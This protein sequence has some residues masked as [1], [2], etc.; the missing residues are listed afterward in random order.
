LVNWAE[1]NVELVDQYKPDML[2]FDN[3]VDQ[4]YLDPLKLWV[5]AY[6]YN[7]AAAWGKQVSIST[8]KAAYAPSGTN[9]E[10]IGSI[11]DF[12]KIGTRSPAG[13]RTGAW[14]VDHP[15]GSSWGYATDM[16][17]SG[18]GAIIEALADTVSKNG[19]L[20][21]NI[22]PTAEGEIPKAQQE[23]LLAVGEWLGTNGEAIYGTHNWFV[24]GEGMPV[25]GQ[26]RSGANVR[27]TVKGDAL[28]AIVLGDSS[29]GMVKLAALG[30]KAEG[31]VKRVTM[32][33]SA[34]E[35]RV[36]GRDASGLTLELPK[37]AGGK[38]AYVLK[39][40]GIKVPGDSATKDG[41]PQGGK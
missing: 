24:F 26:P 14:Q 11:I 22:S 18:P 32:L 19:N 29:G 6:Y 39:V 28:Y 8:K 2:W 31:T 13:I 5:A 41:N 15:I 25:R 10:T 37:G 36:A 17:V 3:G 34:G 40:E 21:L 7:R 1:R 33:G 16:R 9:V 35:A 12:E 27:Y 23:T 20:L 38:Y 30:E 4:R